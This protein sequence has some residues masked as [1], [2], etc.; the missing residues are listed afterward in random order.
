LRKKNIKISEKEKHYIKRIANVSNVSEKIVKDVL[1]TQLLLFTIDFFDSD[2]NES[3]L[4]IPYIADL[5]ITARDKVTSEGVIT[6]VKIE[7][8]PFLSLIEE[9]EAILEGETSPS[10]AFLKQGILSKFRELVGIDE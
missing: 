4:T 5:N 1:L 7:A 9:V 10:E 3:N 6:D 8:T 2:E